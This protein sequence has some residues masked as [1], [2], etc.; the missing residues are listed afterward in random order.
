MNAV[1]TSVVIAGVSSWHEGHQVAR[2]VLDD[3]PHLPAHCAVEAFSV[4]TRLPPPYRLA[5][6]QAWEL[7]ADRFRSPYLTLPGADY[8]RLLASMPNRAIRGGA[9]YDAL[10]AATVRRANVSL[11][12][13]DLRAA[14]TYRRLDVVFE[15]IG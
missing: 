8:R 9:V 14:E 5:A 4:L 6:A 3:D 15:F 10:V 2:A 12:T 7:L 1:D 11:I 13:R